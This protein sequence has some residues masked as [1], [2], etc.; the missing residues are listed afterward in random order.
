MHI[1]ENSPSNDD[2]SNKEIFLK[3]IG[4]KHSFIWKF[5]KNGITD[6][7]L[8]KFNLL[9]T[10]RKYLSYFDKGMRDTWTNEE[11]IENYR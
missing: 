11:E 6:N 8:I 7:E 3:K 4:I 1:E 2:Y 10:L 9:Q 5:F